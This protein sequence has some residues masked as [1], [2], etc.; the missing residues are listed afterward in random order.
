MR[1]GMGG[2]GNKPSLFPSLFVPAMPVVQLAC[3][4]MATRFELV[5]HG[6]DPVH[7]RAAGEEA[8]AE[9]VRLEARLSFY[10]P[11]SD[12]SRINRQAADAPVAVEPWLFALLDRAR[13]LSEETDGAF[14]P[15]V[16]PLMRCW[17][18]VNH[19]GHLPDAAA[20][21]AARAC[22]GMHRVV[23]DP[24]AHTVAFTQP[25]IELDLGGIGKGYAVDEAIRL[26]RELGITTALLHGGTSTVYALGHPPEAAAWQVALPL[27]GTD[28]TPL[29]VVPLREEAL[30]VSAVWGKAFVAEG[31][32]YGHVL[33]P[34]RGH[35]VE[36]AVMAAVVAP[37]AT[38]T[39]ARSTA[40]LVQGAEALFDPRFH[41]LRAVVVSSP[42]AEGRLDAWACGLPLLAADRVR[43]LTPTALP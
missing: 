39:D 9:I 18:F 22:T 24:A 13:Q 14:D 17:G 10:R 28:D 30:S 42:D 40:L 19:T 1:T 20:L 31:R 2:G 4:A 5:L 29:A 11:T 27:P 21:A 7:L 37:S 36:G 34:R 25:G 15:T 12:L 23:L 35:P 8:L 33:D 3:Q 41:V 43:I 38:D 6:D 32:T 26:L 16:A